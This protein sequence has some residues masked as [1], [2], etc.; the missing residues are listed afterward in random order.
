MSELNEMM[1]V[2]I[3]EFDVD[4]VVFVK[5]ENSCLEIESNF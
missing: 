4:V 3:F 5:L 1:N 2:F